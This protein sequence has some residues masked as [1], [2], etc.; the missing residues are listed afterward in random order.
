[1]WLLATLSHNAIVANYDW[2]ILI[3]I[4]LTVNFT[5]L[6]VFSLKM[7]KRLKTVFFFYYRYSFVNLNIKYLLL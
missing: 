3:L 2:N 7:V 6:L 4:I 1:M 5:L